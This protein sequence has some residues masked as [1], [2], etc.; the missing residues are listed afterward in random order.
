MR[1]LG[2]GAP[3]GFASHLLEAGKVI[4]R[5]VLDTASA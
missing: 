4:G 2:L 5:I 1:A 3:G